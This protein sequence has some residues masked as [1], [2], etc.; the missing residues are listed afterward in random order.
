VLN[1]SVFGGSLGSICSSTALAETIATSSQKNREMLRVALPA[2]CGVRLAVHNVATAEPN[3][4]RCSSTSDE[5]ELSHL[6]NTLEAEL[7]SA[8][9]STDADQSLLSDSV[10]GALPRSFPGSCPDRSQNCH[11]GKRVE[12]NKPL[13]GRPSVPLQ[14]LFPQQPSP[15]RL[16][17]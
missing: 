12:K 10:F 11:C 15:F 14:L 8:S 7:M 1:D 2:P 3:V 16:A 6:G 4:R 9:W 17:R 5:P 13:G